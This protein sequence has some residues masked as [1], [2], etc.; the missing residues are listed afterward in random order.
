[1]YFHSFK[2]FLAQGHHGFYVWLAYGT[3][4]TALILLVLWLWGQERALIRSL[5]KRQA[6]MQRQARRQQ[7]ESRNEPSS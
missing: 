7:G 6:R 5:Q 3:T 4:L 2:A 1:M